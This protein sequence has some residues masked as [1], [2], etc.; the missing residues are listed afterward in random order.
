MDDTQIHDHIEQ[1]VAEEQRLYER[2]GNGEGLSPDER[3][4]LEAIKVELDRYWDLLRQRKAL[5]EFGRDPDD[6]SLRSADTV[7]RYEG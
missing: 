6:A 4:R 1:L 3:A 7:E 2:A 5:E